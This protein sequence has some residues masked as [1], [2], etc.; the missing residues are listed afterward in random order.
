[1]TIEEKY[2]EPRQKSVIPKKKFDTCSPTLKTDQN[3]SASRRL[4]GGTSHKM[5]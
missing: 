1:M 4:K 5:C 3:L 2:L